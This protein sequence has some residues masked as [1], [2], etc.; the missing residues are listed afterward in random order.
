MTY[1][2]VATYYKRL[3]SR[4]GSRLSHFRGTPIYDVSCCTVGRRQ[5]V[6][7]S[8]S[9]GRGSIG[10]VESNPITRLK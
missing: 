1:W 3:S 8:Q 7:R 2:I 9:G 6:I 10:Y 5:A 4:S